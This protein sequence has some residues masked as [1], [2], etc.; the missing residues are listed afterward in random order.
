MPA[1]T[2]TAPTGTAAIAH[3]LV[4]LC[5]QGRNADAIEQ[6]Y[7]GDINSIESMG[8][9]A[10]PAEVQG[11]DAVRKKH[12]WWTENVQ[13]HSATTR[14]PFIGDNEFAVFFEYDTTFKPTGKRNTMREMALYT[15]DNG[16]IVREEFFYRTNAD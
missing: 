10:M 15:V 13:V 8:N 3:E 7:A 16:K 11:I 5:R 2:T 9:E 14:G 12:E 4:D 6:F 1:T